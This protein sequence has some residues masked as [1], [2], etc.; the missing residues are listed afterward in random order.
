MFSSSR[1]SQYSKLFPMCGLVIL[2]DQ[3]RKENLVLNERRQTGGYTKWNSR[4]QLENSP[5]SVVSCAHKPYAFTVWLEAPILLKWLLPSLMIMS[6]L[7]QAH[8]PQA[9]SF[10]TNLHVF[11]FFR[12]TWNFTVL[13]NQL[14]IY[15]RDRCRGMRTRNVSLNPQHSLLLSSSSHPQAAIGSPT[16]VLQSL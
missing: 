9:A 6:P 4:A 3:H 13:K 5:S 12:P 8:L 10:I 16:A 14:S 1:L 15:Q 11:I 2:L 7:S